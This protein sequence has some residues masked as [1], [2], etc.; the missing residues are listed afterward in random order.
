MEVEGGEEVVERRLEGGEEVRGEEVG[1]EEI[2]EVSDEVRGT[3]EP[4]G[5]GRWSLGRRSPGRWSQV[6]RRQRRGGGSHSRSVVMQATK[7]CW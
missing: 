3:V 6:E 1:G 2:K 5:G 4:G 7:A